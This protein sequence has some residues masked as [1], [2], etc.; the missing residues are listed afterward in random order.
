MFND[1][2]RTISSNVRVCLQLFCLV[3]IL[4]QSKYKQINHADT[5][6]DSTFNHFS[7]LKESANKRP[8]L[9]SIE[10]PRR[11]LLP[12]MFP[13]QRFFRFRM[14]IN[15][16]K[17]YFPNADTQDYTWG[18]PSLIAP[19]VNS[20]PLVHIFP[21]LASYWLIYSSYFFQNSVLMV[22]GHVLFVFPFKRHPVLF[23]K[24]SPD[25]QHALIHSSLRG[26]LAPGV[27]C[28]PLHSSPTPSQSVRDRLSA[29]TYT[30]PF[31]Q[32]LGHTRA[33]T[34]TDTL[35]RSVGT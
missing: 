29:H 17:K 11:R 30:E 28:T 13:F 14:I 27:M 3:V 6:K 25:I 22:N 21:S 23:W 20:A 2:D 5:F 7:K 32:S 33:L 16:F 9:F 18:K 26:C 8:K 24:V 12:V 35:A 19:L 1:R 34:R 10:L 4:F 31:I 15:A